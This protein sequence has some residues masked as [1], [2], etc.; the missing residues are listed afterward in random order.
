MIDLLYVH[1]CEILN[2]DYNFG[3]FVCLCFQYVQCFNSCSSEDNTSS[4]RRKLSK[5]DIDGECCNGSGETKDAAT[6]NSEDAHGI[7][8]ICGAISIR[9]SLSVFVVI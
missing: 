8:C 4:K 5:E 2:C 1:G 9:F 3:V 6:A 7:T